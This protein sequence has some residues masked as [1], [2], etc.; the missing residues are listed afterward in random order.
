MVHHGWIVFRLE[1]I[2][3]I[4]IAVLDLA[5]N[6]NNDILDGTELNTERNGMGSGG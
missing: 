6:K 2:I 1:L 4:K 3:K 5:I